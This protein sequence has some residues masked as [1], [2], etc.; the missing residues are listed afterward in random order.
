MLRDYCDR[1]II[2]KFDAI[3][4]SEAS[5]D[6]LKFNEKVILNGLEVINQ[7]TPKVYDKSRIL[8]VEEDTFREAGLIAQ[9]VLQTDLSFC[10]SGGDTTDEVG[11]FT[12][13]AYK[14][15]YN[16]VLAYLITAVKELEARLVSAGI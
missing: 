11:N 6:R 5:D 3:S 16:D 14:V 8:N 15:N 4:V 10:V 2:G 13:E 9:E 7:L 1:Q 12:E